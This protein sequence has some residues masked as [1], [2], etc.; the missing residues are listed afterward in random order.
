MIIGNVSFD[1]YF[2]TFASKD[3]YMFPNK[4][5][6]ALY[7]TIRSV[8][9]LFPGTIVNERFSKGLSG[10]LNWDGSLRA[11][12]KAAINSEKSGPGMLYSPTIEITTPAGKDIN[13]GGSINYSPWNMVDAD[14]AMNGATNSP[15]K[16]KGKTVLDIPVIVNFDEMT[17]L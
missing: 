16:V 9:N 1:Y 3:V 2:L 5:M 6:S 15:I 14:L 4:V 12:V 10:R 7:I 17:I 11:A 13:V 8:N